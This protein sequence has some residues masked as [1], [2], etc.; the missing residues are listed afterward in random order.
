VPALGAIPTFKWVRGAQVSDVH[1]I[2]VDALELDGLTPSGDQ[3]PMVQVSVGVYDAFT[4][5]ALPP[6][7]ERIARQGRANIE[8]GRVWVRPPSGDDQPAGSVSD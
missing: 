5:A 6:L 8:I 4:T 7:D 1:L 3:S 2:A